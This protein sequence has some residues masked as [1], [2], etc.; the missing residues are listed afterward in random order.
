MNRNQIILITFALLAVA[1]LYFFGNTKPILSEKAKAKK[2][3][4]GTFDIDRYIAESKNRLLLI[5]RDSITFLEKDLAKA[6]TAQD[7]IKIYA[8]LEKLWK[9]NGNFA[10]ASEMS[11]RKAVTKKATKTYEEAGKKLFES[12]NVVQDSLQKQYFVDKALLAFETAY[13][14]DNS[15]LDAKISQAEILIDVKNQVMP[16]VQA[17]LAIVRKHPDNERANLVLARLAVVSGQFDKAFARLNR[18]IKNNPQNAEAYFIL[19]GAYET[20]GEINMAIENYNLC[21]K[22]VKDKQ[23]KERL[24]IYLK[25]IK[26][27]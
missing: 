21:K 26:S 11:F 10:S 14:L 5:P 25:N 19:A 22:Y 9:N 17:L 18:I 20:K 4:A 6:R 16:G 12:F 3:N 15:N 1:A 23:L 2:A 8:E 13:N 27:K 24:E 7:S